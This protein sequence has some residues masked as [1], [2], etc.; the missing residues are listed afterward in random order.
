MRI[1]FLCFIV[2]PIMEL[3]VLIEVGSV[4][5]VLNTILAVL[6]T[7]VIGASLLRHQGLKTLFNAN[8]KMKEGQMPVSE[9][10]EGL[11]LAVAGALLLTPGFV[12]DIVGFLLLTPG[13]RQLMLKSVTARLVKGVGS[14]SASFQ[15]HYTEVRKASKGEDG[16]IIEG[17]YIR[18][19]EIE[20]PKDRDK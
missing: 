2:M 16:D 10:G 6:L 15:Y 12:T 11:M 3:V 14:Q 19:E 20:A 8:Q 4:I 13:V 5:G 7:A 17:E 18:G 9:M 1:L